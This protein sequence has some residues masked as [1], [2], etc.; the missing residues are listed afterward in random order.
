M[1]E[2]SMA[3]VTREFVEYLFQKASLITDEL[4]DKADA[5]KADYLAVTAA[6]AAKNMARWKSMLDRP[7]SGTAA[8]I[9][10][11]EMANMTAS[12][13]KVYMSLRMISSSF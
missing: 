2:G 1:K 3:N 9:G 4:R 5:C 7:S 6:G 10:Y 8:L 13:M 11:S 12:T